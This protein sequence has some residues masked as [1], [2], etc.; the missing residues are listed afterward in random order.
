MSRMNRNLIFLFSL[1]LSGCEFPNDP[2]NTLKNIEN[3]HSM[4]VGICTCKEDNINKIEI[5]ILHLLTKKLEANITFVEGNQENLY[6]QL[7]QNKLD[8]VA[9]EIQPTSPWKERI[10]FSDPFSLDST[11]RKHAVFALP[12]GENAWLKYINEFLY[13]EK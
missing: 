10:T 7:E 1:L 2:D 9:C 5:S 8:I 12:Q 3:T 13:N 4:R 6:S 11:H